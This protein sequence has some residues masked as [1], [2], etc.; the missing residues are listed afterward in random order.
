MQV[1]FVINRPMWLRVLAQAVENHVVADPDWRG[2]A[3][4]V[5]ADGPRRE[6]ALARLTE[7]I[8]ELRAGLGRLL[9]GDDAAVA[10][11]I[12]ETSGVKPVE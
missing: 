2:Y 12:L 4:D 7:M 1:N 8:P 6:A 10:R 11:R 3:V 9:E 5:F